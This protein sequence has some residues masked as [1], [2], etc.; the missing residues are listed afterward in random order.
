MSHSR[1][2]DEEAYQAA[3]EAHLKSIVVAFSSRR[4]NRKPP[5]VFSRHERF[6][7]DPEDVAPTNPTDIEV[8]SE[9]SH[10]ACFPCKKK[11]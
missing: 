11:K 1:T 5:Q 3:R 10:S 4:S 2:D 7:K 8:D 9:R 6:F